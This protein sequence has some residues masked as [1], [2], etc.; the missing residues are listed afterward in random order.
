MA[1]KPITGKSK[2]SNVVVSD[3][4]ETNKNE[5]LGVV[6]KKRKTFKKTYELGEKD[7][8][9]LKNI[10]KRINDESFNKI[11]ETSIIKGLIEIGK[12]SKTEKIIKAIKD[13]AF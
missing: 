12:K 7:V 5:K 3:K 4:K 13:A 1:K 11:S 8:E 9:K 6:S 2:L 10:V